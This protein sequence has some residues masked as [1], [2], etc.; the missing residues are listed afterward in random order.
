MRFGGLMK[1]LDELARELGYLQ[2]D[3]PAEPIKRW[4][5]GM[6]PRLPDVRLPYRD[7]VEE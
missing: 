1:R 6:Q 7:D 5:K 4:P 3:G 2:G